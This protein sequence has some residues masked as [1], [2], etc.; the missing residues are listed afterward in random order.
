[1]ALPKKDRQ[2]SPIFTFD[3]KNQLRQAVDDAVNRPAAYTNAIVEE[4][5]KHQPMNFDVPVVISRR[6]TGKTSALVHFVGERTLILPE[7]E[8]I[9]VVCPTDDIASEFSHHFNKH[10]PTLKYPTICNAK[11]PVALRAHKFAEVY[12]EEF[13]LIHQR[14]LHN[15]LTYTFDPANSPIIIGVGTIELPTT[16]S[17]QI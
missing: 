10:F 7:T 11:N 13:F 15:L 12:I 5:K 9:A 1:M 14:D 17:I 6:A 4:F 8:S 16:I 3:I 2:P